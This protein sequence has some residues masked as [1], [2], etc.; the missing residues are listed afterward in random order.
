[1]EV[2]KTT[3]RKFGTGT[4]SKFS[5]SDKRIVNSLLLGKNYLN[6]TKITKIA[7]EKWVKASQAQRLLIYNIN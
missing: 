2:P 7:S 1:M 5:D 6:N 3:E 4:I